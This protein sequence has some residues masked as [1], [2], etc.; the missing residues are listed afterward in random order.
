MILRD[1]HTHPNILKKPE[2]ADEFVRRAAELGL[3]E[4]VFTDHMPFSRTGDEHDRIPPGAVG[5]YCRA[6]RRTAKKYEDTV[7][8]SCGIEIDYHPDDVDE[9]KDVLSAGEFDTVLGS[10]HLSIFGYGY[11]YGKMTF[12]D[13]AALV[14]ENTVSAAE[15]GLFD[16]MTHLDIYRIVFTWTDDHP[17]T[18]DGFELGRVEPT[19]RAA[20]RAMEKN[21]A[22]LEINT[23]PLYKSFDTFGVYPEKR[24]LDIAADYSLRYVCGSDAHVPERVGYGFNLIPDRG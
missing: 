1:G 15:S 5:E 21:G 16:V 18:D 11:D 9:I 23:A 20:F 7:R 13:Y 19:L 6:V 22:A 8:V 3:S 2:Q 14:L 17:L 4:I 10:S 12:T 24:I